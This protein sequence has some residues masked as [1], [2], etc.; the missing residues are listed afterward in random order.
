MTQPE[1]SGQQIL[2]LSK[3]VVRRLNSSRVL[4]AFV[5]ALFIL[6][7]IVIIECTQLLLFAKNGLH[8]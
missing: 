2:D 8:S 4:R 3:I 1:K 7:D 6:D 5:K